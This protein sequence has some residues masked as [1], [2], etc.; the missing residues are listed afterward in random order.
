VPF[1]DSDVELKQ[2]PDAAIR[3]I[4][5]RFGRI[6]LPGRERKVIARLLREALTSW[7][8]WGR[9]HRSGDKGTNRSGDILDLAKAP[10]ELLIARVI[11]PSVRGRFSQQ[12]DLARQ[13]IRMLKEREPIYALADLTLDARIHARGNGRTPFLPPL[14][15]RS[16][17]TAHD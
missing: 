9:A 17:V 8:G 15:E 12:G 11:R 7:H 3:E 5:E 16:L 4:F 2:R 13:S 1:H 6:G 10:V 14:T